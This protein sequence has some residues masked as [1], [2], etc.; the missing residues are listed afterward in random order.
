MGENEGDKLYQ[1]EQNS[2]FQGELGFKMTD[3]V[4]IYK[5]PDSEVRV[6]IMIH[7]ENLWLT[8]EKI[9]QLFGVKRPAVTKHLSNIF[10]EGELNKDSVCSKMEHTASDGK[11][12]QTNF[13]NLDAIIS[14]GY[15]INSRQATMFRIWATQVLKEYMQKG[16]VMNDERLK[17]PNYIFGKDYFDEQLERIRDIRSS[18]RRFYQKITDVYAQCSSDYD[19]DSEITKEFYATVQNKMHYAIT[20]QTAAEIICSRADSSLPNMGLTSW[21]NGPHGM[22]RLGDVL[23]AKNYLTEKEI[24]ELNLLASA[25]LD[26]AELQAKR[27]LIMTMQDWVEKLNEFLSLSNYGILESKGT[28]TAVQ[29]KNRAENEFRK[30]HA[31]LLSV[32]QS[33]FDKYL[34]SLEDT[35]QM[36]PSESEEGD[37]E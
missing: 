17:D 3:E 10:K 22:I 19:R 24:S 2:L 12:Y 15:R 36:L 7:D 23:V 21:K 13:Y 5:T 6:E 18:E 34:A 30:Y 16:Y 25:Y 33:D 11:R 9:A 1:G 20:G 8:Q 4:L 32:Y 14:V 26:F 27:G 31:N 29:A 35:Q 28:R 37:Q